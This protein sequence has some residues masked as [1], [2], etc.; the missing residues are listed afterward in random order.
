MKHG[1]FHVIISFATE[2][3]TELM[4]TNAAGTYLNG[5]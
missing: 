1:I 5:I 4:L 2:G 3:L